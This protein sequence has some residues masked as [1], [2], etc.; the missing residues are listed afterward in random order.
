[1]VFGFLLPETAGEEMPQ[2]IEEANGFGMR[3]EV[4]LWA[5]KLMDESPEMDPIDAY[6]HGFE[7]WIK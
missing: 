4:K 3:E 5:E 1:M 7:E 2:T 6:T